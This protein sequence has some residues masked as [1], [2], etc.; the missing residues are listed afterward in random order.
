MTQL[1]YVNY[2]IISKVFIFATIIRWNELLLFVCHSF[3]IES[4]FFHPL[5]SLS[6]LKSQRLPDFPSISY[7]LQNH[8]QQRQQT[9]PSF[10]NKKNTMIQVAMWNLPSWKIKPQENVVAISANQTHLQRTLASYIKPVFR[11]SHHLFSLLFS[12]AETTLV[13]LF[14]SLLD[15]SSSYFISLPVML[16]WYIS[17]MAD[18]CSYWFWGSFCFCYFS[19]WLDP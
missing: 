15:E 19:I 10:C 12:S 13:S 14:L 8:H 4:S 17:Y 18:L 6:I 7:C 9:E 1:L 3:L 11:I 2:G 5:V 16:S